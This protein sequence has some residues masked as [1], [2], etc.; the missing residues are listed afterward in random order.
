MKPPFRL[1]AEE[2]PHETV[3]ATRQL[4]DHGE[5]G[6]P[7]RGRLIGL[8]YMAMYKNRTYVV[9]ATGECFRNPDVARG[10]LAQLHDALGRLA[11]GEDPGWDAE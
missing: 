1:V 10:Y 3:S 11:R 5:H 7:K 6:H 4:L 8:G 9:N 2:V